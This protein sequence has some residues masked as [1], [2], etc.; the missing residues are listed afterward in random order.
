MPP[1]SLIR[2]IFILNIFHDELPLKLSGASCGLLGR[3]HRGLAF[4]VGKEFWNERFSL[5][6][7]RLTSPMRISRSTG[8]FLLLT[9]SIEVS[10]V[11]FSTASCGLLGRQHRGLAFIVGKEFWNERF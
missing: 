4:I 2:A 7:R 10:L 9:F 1:L 3:Q 5:P 6:V 8:R 11:K